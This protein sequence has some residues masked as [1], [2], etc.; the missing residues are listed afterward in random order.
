MTARAVV[1][2]K[3]SCYLKDLHQS[4]LCLMHL[5]KSK[6]KITGDV[7]NLSAVWHRGG[8]LPLVASLENLKVVDTSRT[9]DFK[10][11][12]YHPT[13]LLSCSPLSSVGT[14][15]LVPVKREWRRLCSGEAL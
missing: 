13:I 5:A 14:Y 4:S 12:N 1:E 9:V 7:R 3:F 10:K 8:E 6:L 2:T 15:P 11:R